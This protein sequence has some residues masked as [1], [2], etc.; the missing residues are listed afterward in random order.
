MPTNKMT[1]I[2][3]MVREVVV[4]REEKALFGLLKF[5]R[6]VSTTSIGDTLEIITDIEPSAVYLNGKLLVYS[7]N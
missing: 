7:N 5:W 3:P 4:F 6:K 1:K 2:T